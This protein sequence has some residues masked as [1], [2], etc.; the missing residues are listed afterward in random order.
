VV[1]V[2]E[3]VTAR[4]DEQ[5]LVDLNRRLDRGEDPATVASGWLASHGLR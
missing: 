2:V 3:R 5:T 4:L 1:E